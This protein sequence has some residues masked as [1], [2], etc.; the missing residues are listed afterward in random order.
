MDNEGRS[1][2][3]LEKEL[4]DRMV[5]R[6]CSQVTI[7]GYRYLCNSIINQIKSQGN[8]HY[9]KVSGNK[10]LEGYLKTNGNN[11]YYENLKTVVNRL[12]DL[13][14]GTWSEI[15]SSRGIKFN[16]TDQQKIV[17]DNYCKYYGLLGRTDGTV[18]LK[19]YA[20]QLFFSKLNE[21]ECTDIKKISAENIS[22]ACIRITN[23]NI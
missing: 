12:N 23:H 11:Q 3:E 6:G 20:I 10:V 14:D 2:D 4:L 13:M 9:T 15:H 16:L 22:K 19:R 5:S 17:V 8:H 21:I 18:R 7:T 1:F